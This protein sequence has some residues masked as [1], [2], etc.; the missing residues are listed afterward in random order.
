L[1][2]T[3][4]TIIHTL[5]VTGSDKMVSNVVGEIGANQHN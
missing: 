1:L 4:G 5:T 2:N 3:I